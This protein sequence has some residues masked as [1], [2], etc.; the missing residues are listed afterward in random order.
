[1]RIQVALASFFETDEQVPS[2]STPTADRISD[3]DTNESADNATQV[4]EITRADSSAKS[5]SR[6]ATLKDVQ[7]KDSSDEEEGQAFYAGGSENSGQQVL[8]PGMKK[9]LITEMFKSCQ[10]QSLSL[11]NRSSNGQ[12]RKNFS[13]IG[14]KLGQTS[15]DAEGMLMIY[16]FNFCFHLTYQ[17]PLCHIW[18]NAFTYG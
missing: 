3:S 4:T 2:T 10:E 7:K 15:S 6:I 18:R 5:K 13:G 14:Y 17:C 16:C 12:K 11:E 9:D 8:G 1:M